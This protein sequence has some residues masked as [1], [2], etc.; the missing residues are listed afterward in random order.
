MQ[1]IRVHAF[2]PD[3]LRYEEVPLPELKAGEVLVRTQ[4]AGVNPIDWKTCSGGG[5][6]GFIEGLPFIPG[7]EFSGVVE[8]CAEDVSGFSAGDEVMGFVRFPYPAGCYAE[9]VAV[10]ASEI[11]MRP[12]PLDV[13]Q[14]A[15]LP[16]AGLTAW[17]A[18]FEAGEL[19][20][21]QS[22]LVLAGAGG[23]GHLAVQLAH[24]H[25]A[26]VVATASAANAPWLQDLG[27]AEVIDY[28]RA[29]LHPYAERFDLIL[30]AVGGET[31]I[32]AMVALKSGGCMVTLPSVTASQVMRAA[33][34]TDIRVKTLRARPD[35]A[36]LKE[37]A[38]LA[39]VGLLRVELAASMP[40]Q[41]A[42][43]AHQ[44][45]AAGHVRGK[46]VL[47]TGS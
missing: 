3:N 20:Q 25:K 27:C 36:Q 47:L 46:L 34:G 40:L 38:A 10:P 17:Q 1:A 29:D 8:R 16:L 13:Q 41:E 22:L 9:Y 35:A 19:K 45:S 39:A 4:A 37:L 11:C 42:A 18:L 2:E 30:D 33:E 23:V 44:L 32:D 24:L 12:Q 28:H 26:Q 43:R 5:A 6:S 21:G 15:A 7:W 31:A 14:A